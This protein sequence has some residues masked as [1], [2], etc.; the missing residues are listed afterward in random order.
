VRVNQ[1]IFDELCLGTFSDVS[2]AYYVSLIAQ[3]AEQ[4]AQGVIFGCTEIG[5][6]VSQ[7]QS[8]IPVFDTAALH[9]AD[10]VTFM[11]S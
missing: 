9:A 4:G 1:V 6:L 8:P 3:L 7:D 5:L 10:A 2:R 11:L